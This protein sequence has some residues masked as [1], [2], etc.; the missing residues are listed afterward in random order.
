MRFPDVDRFTSTSSEVD[1]FTSLLVRHLEVSP[2]PV[3]LAHAHQH[4][5]ALRLD[6]CLVEQGEG[7]LE[8]ALRLGQVAPLD[9]QQ[10]EVVLGAC[11]GEAVGQRFVDANRPM[12]VA[13][14]VVE[15]ANL[16]IRD[17]Q[18]IEHE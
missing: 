8:M 6:A 9:Q 5:R 3:K 18:V 11:Q 12:G 17:A 10:T 13:S 16:S 2:L 15:P 7:T 14:G 4:V 1:G